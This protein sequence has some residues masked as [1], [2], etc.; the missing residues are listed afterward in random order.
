MICLNEWCDATSVHGDPLCAP[1][2]TE[3]DSRGEALRLHR[4]HVIAGLALASPTEQDEGL[5]RSLLRVPLTRRI[6]TYLDDETLRRL[7]TVA[8][9]AGTNV[10][11]WMRGAIL[12]RLARDERWT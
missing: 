2:R 3:A 8:R 1:C 6:A 12:Q 4:E 7:E 5:H 11:E 10:S 9:T